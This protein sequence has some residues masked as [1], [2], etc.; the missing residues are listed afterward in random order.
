MA[1]EDDAVKKSDELKRKGNGAM[2]RHEYRDA[3]EAYTEAIALNPHNHLLFSNRAQAYLSLAPLT[4][5]HKPDENPA[6]FYRLSHFPQEA[7][8]KQ[9]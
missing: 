2:G 4:E 9:K 3:I 7:S 5:Q 6:H 1:G 8:V